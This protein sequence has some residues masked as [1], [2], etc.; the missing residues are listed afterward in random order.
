[1]GGV[2][3]IELQGYEG[4][5]QAMEPGVLDGEDSGVRILY[6]QCFL[7]SWLPVGSPV[8]IL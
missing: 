7:V 1:M 5:V 6:F 2:S 3:G 4:G 8:A